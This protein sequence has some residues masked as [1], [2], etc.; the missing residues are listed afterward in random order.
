MAC[1]LTI[2]RARST[3]TSVIRATPEKEG[4]LSRGADAPG[5]MVHTDQIMVS[6][7]TPGR[8]L[9]GYEREGPSSCIYGDTTCSDAYSR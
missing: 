3:E 7:S 2:Q 5:K 9:K 1:K 8:L 6:T 4:S